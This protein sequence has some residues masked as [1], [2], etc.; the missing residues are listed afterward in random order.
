MPEQV[1]SDK[2]FILYMDSLDSACVE[3]TIIAIREYMELEFIEKK[4]PQHQQKFFNDAAYKW[5][6][7]EYEKLPFYKPKTP[8][9]KNF[10]DCGL[11]VLEFA[12]TFLKQ[13]EFVYNNLYQRNATLFHE[14]IVDSKRDDI[15]RIIIAIA[16]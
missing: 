15:M 2:P 3:D 14:R 6:K 10:Y 16:E 1:P 13:P 9:Q 5:K 7:F 4:V 12:E 11:F 8:K